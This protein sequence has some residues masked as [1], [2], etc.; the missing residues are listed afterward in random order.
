M[1]K[2][3]N[4]VNVMTLL[5][6]KLIIEGYFTRNHITLAYLVFTTKE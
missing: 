5:A 1:L 4:I 3:G 2:G 6:R